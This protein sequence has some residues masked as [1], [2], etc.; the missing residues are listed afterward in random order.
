MRRN[1]SQK[2]KTKSNTKSKN[3]SNCNNNST[4]LTAQRQNNPREGGNETG[5]RMGSLSAL[6]SRHGYQ[7]YALTPAVG[8]CGSGTFQRW[9]VPK[10]TAGGVF[11][12]PPSCTSI[13]AQEPPAA[14]GLETHLRVQPYDSS[15]AG[16]LVTK[17]TSVSATAGNQKKSPSA[18][19]GHGI[20]GPNEYAPADH[21]RRSQTSPD[22]GRQRSRPR[23]G[24]FRPSTRCSRALRS[25]RPEGQRS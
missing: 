13:S 24:S 6:F 22:W 7:L 18:R 4:P 9:K 10:D 16:G 25:H 11:R 21:R 5:K 19:E 8:P 3:K 1:N 12:I 17:C 15:G 14:V 2:T 20:K 23:Q